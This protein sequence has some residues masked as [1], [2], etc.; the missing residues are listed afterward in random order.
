MNSEFAVG[1]SL[2]VSVPTNVHPYYT[3]VMRRENNKAA[4]NT[5]MQF[6]IC[7]KRKKPT[8]TV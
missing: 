5:R 4:P 1:Q 3:V 7:N 2:P 6:K 8:V